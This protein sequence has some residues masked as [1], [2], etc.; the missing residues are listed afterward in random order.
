M[1]ENL[2]KKVESVRRTSEESVV[3]SENLEQAVEDV[4]QTAD[5]DEKGVEVARRMFDFALELPPEVAVPLGEYIFQQVNDQIFYEIA[6][7]EEFKKY[8]ERYREHVPL[9]VLREEDIPLR[10]T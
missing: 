7:S 3:K 9:R 5:E 2:E 1:D 10:E 8:A 4:M 6:G